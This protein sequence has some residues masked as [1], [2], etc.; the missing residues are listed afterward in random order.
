MIN[1][2]TISFE[3]A[4]TSW[5]IDFGKV[6]DIEHDGEQI[7]II[8]DVNLDNNCKADMF[9]DTLAGNAHSSD[10]KDWG[11]LDRLFGRKQ[12]Q[13]FLADYADEIRAEIDI[14]D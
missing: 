13:E 11:T 1:L 8:V 2:N 5:N 7:K 14:E 4:P 6:A 9:V 10:T 3:E 12:W